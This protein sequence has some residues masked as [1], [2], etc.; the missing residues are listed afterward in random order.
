MIMQCDWKDGLVVKNTVCSSKGTVF[1]TPTWWLTHIIK[2]SSRGCKI[3]F[4]TPSA[5]CMQMLQRHV[6]GQNTH[7][8][9]FLF[10]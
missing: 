9:M 7:V 5:P 8:H 2:S 4:W 6:L 10:K 3:L 1:P